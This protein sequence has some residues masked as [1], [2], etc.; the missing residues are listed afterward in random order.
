M[1]AARG[2]GKRIE[3]LGQG[4]TGTSAVSF[5]GAAAKFTILS[6]TY[7]TA[8]VPNGATS[9]FI[10]VTTPSGT[11]KSNKKFLVRPFHDCSVSRDC[12]RR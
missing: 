6:D 10:T 9:G 3:V 1:P 11:L 5:N 2:V 12:G 4:F 8:T 7:L